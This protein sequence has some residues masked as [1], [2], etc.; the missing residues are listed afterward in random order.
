MEIFVDIKSNPNYQISNEGKVWS[1]F[2]CKHMKTFY[3]RD[4]YL[5]VGLYDRNGKGRIE[6]VHRLVAIAFIDNPDR[7]PEVNHKNHIRDD[8]RA[9]NLEWVSHKGNCV[10]MQKVHK[11]GKFNNNVLVKEYDTLTQAA[12]DN[13]ASALT[14]RKYIDNQKEYKGYQYKFID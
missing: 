5:R 10:K 13:K 8:N 1:K 9:E 11:V 14:I 7:L 12:V 6:L 3:D 2:R 4:G